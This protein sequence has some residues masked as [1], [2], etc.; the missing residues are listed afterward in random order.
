MLII[1]NIV[2]SRIPAWSLGHEQ[3]GTMVG[4]VVSSG[5][6]LALPFWPAADYEAAPPPLAWK[7]DTPS[8]GQ[9]ATSQGATSVT[10]DRIARVANGEFGRRGGP[11][12][13]HTP[14]RR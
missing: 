2:A 4:A 6:L 11:I 12:K 1:D 9:G 14:R 13:G 10:A 3:H 5:L 8:R 7:P